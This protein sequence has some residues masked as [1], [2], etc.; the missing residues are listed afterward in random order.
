VG[1]TGQFNIAFL[2]PT[3]GRPHRATVQVNDRKDRVQFS[4]KA[5]MMD[6]KERGKLANRIATR[7]K[8]KQADVTE[9]V[10]EAWN[11]FLNEKAQAIRE[12]AEQADKVAVP[13]E[14]CPW[15]GVKFPQAYCIAPDGC[16]RLMGNVGDEA[17]LLAR[18]PVWVEAFARDYRCGG[19]GHLLAW[20]DRDGQMH[21]AAFPAG[22]FHEQSLS[23]VQELAGGGLAVV[24]GQERPL[25]RYLAAFEV[26]RRVR[27]VTR[28]GWVDVPDVPVPVYVFPGEVIGDA[29]AEEPVY[30]PEVPSALAATPR[31]SGTLKEW[32]KTV[33]WRARDNPVLLFSLSVAFTGA[34]L[35]FA[36]VEGGGFHLYGSSS[37]GKTTAGQFA[38][39][40]WGSGADPAEAPGVAFVR[41]WNATANAVEAIAADHCDGL[42]VLDEVGEAQVQDLGRLIYQ[43]AGGQGKNRLSRDAAL[44]TPRTWRV[45][46]LSTGEVPVQAVIE[47]TG[48]KARGGQLVRMVDV[49]ATGEDGG[50]IHEPHDREP[51]EFVHRTKRACANHFGT[52]GPAFVRFLCQQGTIADLCKRVGGELAEAHRLLAPEG[53]A[54]EVSRVVRR[55]ALVLVAGQLAS[56]ARV[57]PFSHAEVEKAVRLVLGRW[58]DVHGRGPMERALEQLRAFL[59]RNESRFRDHE[60]VYKSV[61]DLAGYKDR[62]KGLFLLTRE[63][64]QEALEGFSV[65]D[66]MRY[67]RD[68]D[69][70]FVNEGNRL[71]SGHRIRG[72]D[73][74]IRLY[75]V[76]TSLLGEEKGADDEENGDELF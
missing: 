45:V 6:A 57:L 13:A 63:G 64:A 76:R 46:V 27:S 30:Q 12:A 74:V 36:G 54:E 16:V 9:K 11:K 33:A 70:L 53:A 51:A 48:R 8:L 62:A 7:F 56:S 42:L 38:A 41:K 37:K 61:H 17:Q 71:L 66:V 19:W 1:R 67:L 32:Q 23:L 60:D 72:V 65:R 2:V 14:G 52:A 28:L 58:L 59:L 49:P 18:G 35:R 39:S 75:A 26:T 43:L 29:G 22:R 50:I 21:R 10:E 31:S 5:D 68:Q 15:E 4:D 73:R 40:V 34:L 20:R 24:P 25:L 3:N 44:R 55:F 47:A 69:L